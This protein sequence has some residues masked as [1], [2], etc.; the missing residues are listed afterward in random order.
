MTAK[1]E[2]IRLGVV[3]CGAVAQRHHLSALRE[4]RSIKVTAVADSDTARLALIA[5]EFGIEQR[6]RN[7]RELVQS[8]NIDAVAVCTPPELHE[9]IALAAIENGK[10][11]FV[12]K[13]LTLTLESCQ[14]LA[15]TVAKVPRLKLM[16]GFNLRQHRLILEARQK[17]QRGELGRIKLVR[18]VFTNGSRRQKD[19]AAWRKQKGSGGGA[20][21]ELGVHHFDIVRFLCDAEIA[22]VSSASVSEDGS[23]TVAARLDDGTQLISA[24]SEN[25][26]DNQ[27]IEVY[28]ERGRLRVSCYRFDGLEHLS[29]YSGSPTDRMQ[30]LKRKLVSFP[31]FISQLKRGGDY[32]ATYAG[33]WRHFADAIINDKPVNCT[34]EDGREALAVALTAMVASATSRAVRITE[35]KERPTSNEGRGPDE[36]LFLTREATA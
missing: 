2:I 25:A 20:L 24:F 33:E 34:L 36:A 26:T 6:F 9:E 11:T 21:F 14:R 22:E 30:N 27:E 8:E 17:I 10:H 19:C 7:Y 13:P 23:A 4:V 3:G 35:V 15:N 32:V 29:E 1:T 5:E 12:E 18:T 16:V 31:R 28:G